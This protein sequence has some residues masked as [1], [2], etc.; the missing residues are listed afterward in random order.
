MQTTCPTSVRKVSNKCPKRVKTCQNNVPQVPEKCPKSVKHMSKHM[1]HNYQKS[2]SKQCPTSVQEVSKSVKHMSKQC[3][4]TCQTS[5]KTCPTSVKN[6]SNTY[7]TSVQQVSQKCSKS[8]K[9]VSQKSPNHAQ[10]L[11]NTCLT[12]VFALRR[13]TCLGICCIKQFQSLKPC[14]HCSG[15]LTL[16]ASHRMLVLSTAGQLREPLQEAGLPSHTLNQIFH[17]IAS[18]RLGSC[19]IASFRIGPCKCDSASYRVTSIV[20]L[21]WAHCITSAVS[22]DLTPLNKRWLCISSCWASSYHTW[23]RNC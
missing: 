1:S 5:I 3:Q 2:V 21:W 7:P 11:S 13:R 9:Q 8:V 14:L 22:L 17:R 20:P 6:M 4:K 10:Q 16:T 15:F 23:H 12:S 18:Q 19:G